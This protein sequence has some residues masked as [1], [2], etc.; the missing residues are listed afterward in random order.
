MFSVAK[1]VALL[2]LQRFDEARKIVDKVLNNPESS[3]VDLAR[4]K[5]VLAVCLAENDELDRAKKLV[6][7]ACDSLQKV[8]NKTAD[9][10]LFY[11]PRTI[12]RAIRIY[13]LSDESEKINKWRM[14]LKDIEQR[15]SERVF[16]VTKEEARAFNKK[17]WIRI[18]APPSDD[19]A[20][21]LFE[22]ELPELRRLCQQHP[23]RD[24]Y[25][26]LATAE[27]RMGNF[28]EAIATA[29]ASIDLTPQKNSDVPSPVNFAVSVSYT[30][31]TL[32]TN[33]EV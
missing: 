19:A 12:E 17:I 3:E 13:E 27:Y 25:K 10:R 31:L 6:E 30:H 2:E 23:R 28:K 7:E 4:V 21:P 33:R 29:K 32:P 11:L 22:D 16:L 18:A 15:I 20:G 24:F 26:T 9:H 14:K 1:S 5:S 8:F